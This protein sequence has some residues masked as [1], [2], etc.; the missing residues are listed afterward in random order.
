L[1][2]EQ[3]AAKESY[4]QA[5][6]GQDQVQF[7]SVGNYQDVTVVSRAVAPVKPTKPKK[8]KLFVMA[9]AASFALALGVPFA[10]ELLLNRRIRCR[11][12]L[13]RHFRIVTLAQ[14]E[15]MDPAPSA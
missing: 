15:R 1:L 6:R 10:Y 12:D 13:E 7:A 14:F 4:S 8:M 3:N 2:T 11:D 9:V 5:L